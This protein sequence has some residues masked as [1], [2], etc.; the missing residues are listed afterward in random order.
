MI[1]EKLKVGDEVRVIAPA[2]SLGII[3][4]ENRKI[5]NKR[6]EDM[7]LKLSFGKHVEEIDMF[8]SSS[9]ESRV[10]DFN[11]SFADKNVKMVLPVIGGFNSNQ[12]LRYIDWENV[13]NNPKIFCG[14]SDITALNN[15][16][17][18]KT[19]LVNYSGPVYSSFGMKKYFEYTLEY[20]KKA[21]FFNEPFEVKPSKEF[22]D[23]KWY[24]D[25][26]NRM[27]IKNEGFGLFKMA[28]LKVKLL[29][30]M[31]PL[32]TFLMGQNSNQN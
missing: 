14:C 28:R 19:G 6:F 1:P 25:Q 13:K 31:H 30:E 4:K 24:M 7:G 11:E 16:I 5:A 22:T 26:E 20:F 32:C 18:A 15:A 21:L 17:Y 27:P 10:E 3:S 2:Q 9:I 29:A 23:D 12:L 8:N